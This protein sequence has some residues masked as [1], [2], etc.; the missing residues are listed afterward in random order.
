MPAQNAIDLV[1]RERKLQQS[2]YSVQHDD[3]HS[4]RELAVTPF[5]ILDDYVREQTFTRDVAW[6]MGLAAKVRGRVGVDGQIKALTVA[7]AMTLAEIDRL[8]RIK[9]ESEKLQ[10]RAVAEA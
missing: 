1:T 6:T 4:E 5:L 7:A 3:G 9:A 8:I 10:P 2:R